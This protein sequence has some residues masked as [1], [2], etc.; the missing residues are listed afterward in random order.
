MVFL[1]SPLKGLRHIHATLLLE[2]GEHPKVVQE[3]LGHSTITT[4]INI[5]SHVTPTMQKSAIAD[6]PRTWAAMSPVRSP[7]RTD[8]W[9]SK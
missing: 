9:S 5:Y 4:T 3:R 1:A 7:N 6:S 2:L 8:H